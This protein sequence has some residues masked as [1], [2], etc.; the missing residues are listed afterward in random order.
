[1]AV[2][3]WRGC[4]S[5]R[6]EVA[7]PRAKSPKPGTT[8][9]PASV[10]RV[11]SHLGHWLCIGEG[12]EFRRGTSP[13]DCCLARVREAREIGTIAPREWSAQ[14]HAGLDRGVV[15]DVDGPLVVR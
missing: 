6:L 15:H 3:Q 4:N 9:V 5:G 1:R 13:D 14:L 7:G 12:P 10:L 2:L 11:R 8:S